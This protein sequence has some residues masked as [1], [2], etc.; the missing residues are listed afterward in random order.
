MT[1][2]VTSLRL[3]YKA[4]WLQMHVWRGTGCVRTAFAKKNRGGSRERRKSKTLEEIQ[5]KRFM[6]AV[7]AFSLLAMTTHGQNTPAADL[8]GGYSYLH[9]NGSGGGSG[10][11][12]TRA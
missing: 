6:W 5:M 1:K 9:L 4:N 7:L 10:A 11:N 2:S 8:A 12:K 3:D